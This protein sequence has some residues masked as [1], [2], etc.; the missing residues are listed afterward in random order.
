MNSL[1]VVPT[2][3][4]NYLN[5]CRVRAS[6]AFNNIPNFATGRF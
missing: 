3:L 1:T 4:L 6:D 2:V 5:N